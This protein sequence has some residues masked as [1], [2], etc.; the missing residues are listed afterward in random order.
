MHLLSALHFAQLWCCFCIA[1]LQLFL[2]SIIFSFWAVLYCV[3]AAQRHSFRKK[4]CIRAYACNV[5][6]MI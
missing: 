2:L 5:D 6:F 1:Q 3:I 4:G